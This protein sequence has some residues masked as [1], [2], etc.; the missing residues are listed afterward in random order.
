MKKRRVLSLLALFSMIVIMG[1]SAKTVTVNYNMN[2]DNIAPTSFPWDT[3]QTYP[4]YDLSSPPYRIFLGYFDGKE[5]HKPGTVIKIKNDI[6]LTAMWDIPKVTVTFDYGYPDS[7]TNIQ[8][9]VTFDSE[10]SFPPLPTRNGYNFCYWVDD[11]GNQYDSDE[12]IWIGIDNKHITAVW[13]KNPTITLNY[14]FDNNTQILEVEYGE[15]FTIPSDIPQRQGYDFRNWTD[16]KTG[17]KYTLGKKIYNIKEDIMLNAEWEAKSYSIKLTLNQGEENQDSIIESKYG[18]IISLPYPLKHNGWSF[19]GWTDGS[20]VYKGGSDFIVSG[21]ITLIAKWE[22]DLSIEQ[23]ISKMLASY[24]IPEANIPNDTESVPESSENIQETISYLLSIVDQNI[25]V[26]DYSEAYNI[27]IGLMENPISY[28]NEEVI[29]KY[30]KFFDAYRNNSKVKQAIMDSSYIPFKHW[31]DLCGYKDP[32]G[33]IIIEPQFSDVGEFHEGLAPVLTFPE[34]QLC[35]IN[36]KGEIVIRPEREYRF[37]NGKYIAYSGQMYSIKGNYNEGVCLIYFS[38]KGYTYIDRN[39]TINYDFL[40]NAKTNNAEVKG[41]YF[42]QG[43]IPAQNTNNGYWGYLDKDGNWAIPPQF[44][45]AS[46]FQDGYAIVTFDNGKISLITKDGK[47]NNPIKDNGAGMFAFNDGVLSCILFP[48]HGAPA[49]GTNVDILLYN[50]STNT[51]IGKG[52]TYLF[53]TPPSKIINEGF[54]PIIYSQVNYDSPRDSST[55][56]AIYDVYG[57]LKA[58]YKVTGLVS[59]YSLFDKGKITFRIYE[60]IYTMD[61]FGNVTKTGRLE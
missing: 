12:T 21:N 25:K 55:I 19:V 42:S 40:E 13:E 59:E 54:F 31:N 8:K 58:S 17:S 52:Q 50:P 32:D 28:K 3:S 10:I 41:Q 38:N 2:I 9:E 33:N 16:S 60:D 5:L 18:Q 51:L 6:T 7:P 4:V 35:F 15:D 24:Q 26:E 57:K 14:G 20:S 34:K 22:E 11:Q 36:M 43:L 29:K 53:D 48:S 47:P 37:E 1:L 49:W 27:L 30:D 23:E 44:K 39:G 61:Y 45:L 56:F 46:G